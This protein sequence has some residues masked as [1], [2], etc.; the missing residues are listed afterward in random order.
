VE[1]FKAYKHSHFEAA[2]R[3]MDLA[4]E[5]LR[6][7]SDD[8][9]SFAR[10]AEDAAKFLE[11]KDDRKRAMALYGEMANRFLKDGRWNA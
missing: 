4:L 5:A 6:I 2:M 11:S 7:N 8:P 9:S 3:C 10:V 1:A